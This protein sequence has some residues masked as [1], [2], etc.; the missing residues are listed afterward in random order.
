MRVQGMAIDLLGTCFLNVSKYHLEDAL[1]A[2]YF[3]GSAL[4]TDFTVT[5]DVDFVTLL[6]YFPKDVLLKIRL[7]HSDVCLRHP[8][9]NRLEGGYHVVCNGSVT[10]YRPGV[11]V[12]SIDKIE[13]CDM[14]V[15][16]DSAESIIEKGQLIYGKPLDFYMSRPNKEVLTRFSKEY[17]LNFRT[18]L[19]ER[20]DSNKHFFSAILN[21]CRSI[22]YL[23]NGVFPSKTVA[24]TYVSN[25]FSTHRPIIEKAVQFRNGNVDIECVEEDIYRG[26]AF[27]DSA[28]KLLVDRG[29][30][31]Y[32]K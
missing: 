4:T 7:L 10:G 13:W 22:C 3:Y 23:G 18:R 11:W 32:D 26:L 2:I 27:I 9:G 28:V 19:P 1:L 17:L 8:L 29:A 12:E 30:S 25:I 15:E 5:S 24:A 6:R 16:P 14:E 31:R 20:V 21:A